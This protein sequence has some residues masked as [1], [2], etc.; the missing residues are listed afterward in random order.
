M[1]CFLSFLFFIDRFFS[2]YK[3]SA[4]CWALA[5]REEYRGRKVKRAR[6][7][8]RKTERRQT[9]RQTDRGERKEGFS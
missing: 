1:I 7:R 6:D 3:L 8:K 9:D 2:D 4:R 5:R